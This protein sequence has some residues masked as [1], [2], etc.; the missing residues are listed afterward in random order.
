M[1]DLPPEIW[2][3]I[4]RMA[5]A[6]IPAFEVGISSGSLWD[7]LDDESTPLPGSN[8]CT[9]PGVPS[10]HPAVIQ[11]CSILRT[12]LLPHYYGSIRFDINQNSFGGSE[13]ES[14]GNGCKEWDRQ[15][16]SRL[17]VCDS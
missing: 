5:I 3:K 2:S 9:T 7:A 17:R 12:E 16:D 8:T 10:R 14:L 6:N 1:M 15:R 4:G 13:R 11:V